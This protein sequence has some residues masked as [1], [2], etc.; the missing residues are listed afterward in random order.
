[1]SMN[2]PVTFANGRSL[3]SASKHE[4]RLGKSR[5][6]CLNILKEITDP[7]SGYLALLQGTYYQKVIPIRMTS[8]IYH[9]GNNE[10]KNTHTSKMY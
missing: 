4:T 3:F 8:A 2:H 9:P 5:A 1:M 10:K 7:L 6:M